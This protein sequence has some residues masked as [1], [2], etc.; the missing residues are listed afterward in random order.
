MKNFILPCLLGAS[1]LKNMRMKIN[2]EHNF[3]E[4]GRKRIRQNLVKRPGNESTGIHTVQN[5]TMYPGKMQ[6]IPVRV[7]DAL[8]GRDLLIL[9]EGELEEITVASVN[10][11]RNSGLAYTQ[12]VNWT[13]HPITIKAGQRFGTGFVAA[14]L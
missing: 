4:M 8:D 13:D 2:Y 9:P 1:N 11:V 6:I 7:Q 3:V 14:F 5:M 12:I 10:P